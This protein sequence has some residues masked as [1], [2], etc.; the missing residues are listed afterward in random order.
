ME[1]IQHLSAGELAHV[2]ICLCLIERVILSR[3]NCYNALIVLMKNGEDFIL[4]EKQ[5]MIHILFSMKIKSW[6]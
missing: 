2:I 6:F 1:S 4:S 3:C 5:K